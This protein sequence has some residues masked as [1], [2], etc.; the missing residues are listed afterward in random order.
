MKFLVGDLLDYHQLKAGKFKKNIEKF[1][2]L[3]C[4]SEII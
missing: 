2:I 1:N 4:I 3:D